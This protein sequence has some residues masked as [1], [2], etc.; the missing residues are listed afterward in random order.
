MN[1]RNADVLEAAAKEIAAATGARSR[2]SPATS[3]RKTAARR[4]C[5]PAPRL[6]ILINNNGGPPPKDFRQISREEMIAGLDTNMM[7]R[8]FSFR[9]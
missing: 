3:A 9:P 5:S 2:P 6:D 4:C 1:G 8:S 7:T